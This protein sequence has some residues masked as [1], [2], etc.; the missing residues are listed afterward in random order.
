[1]RIEKTVEVILSNEELCEAVREWINLHC[2][3]ADVNLVDESVEF[4]SDDG[5]PFN[6][7]V[8]A[9]ATERT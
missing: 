7:D 8:T 6:F 5:M 4:L 3:S 1:M 9:R 2:M